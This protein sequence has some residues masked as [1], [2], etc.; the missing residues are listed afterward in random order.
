ML[1]PIDFMGI[2]V[3]NTQRQAAAQNPETA[4]VS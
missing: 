2:Y 1:E 3:A 4:P